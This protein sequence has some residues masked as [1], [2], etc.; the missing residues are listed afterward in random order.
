MQIRCI[1]FTVAILYILF[2][3]AF[4]GW[5]LFHQKMERRRHSSST[6][7]LL[8]V[9]RDDC[10]SDNLQ[11]DVS[12]STEVNFYFYWLFISFRYGQL[13]LQS[14][15]LS[16]RNSWFKSGISALS[17]LFFLSLFFK[18]I[19]YVESYNHHRPSSFL[20]PTWL[21]FSFTIC[22]LFV[23]LNMLLMIMPCS[24]YLLFFRHLAYPFFNELC[25]NWVFYI[26][27][28]NFSIYNVTF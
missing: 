18:I 27:T 6:E 28:R 16:S 5:G 10:D 25:N 11:K 13:D 15:W 2:L 1:E 26:L 7:P 19:S 9:L 20:P 21:Y 8:N 24:F 12:H 17:S 4:F 3:S 23:I 14:M 22:F